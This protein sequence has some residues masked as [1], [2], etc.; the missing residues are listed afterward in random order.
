MKIAVIGAGNIGQTLGGKWAAAGHEVVYG[1]RSAG[2][3]GTAAIGDA[4]PGSEVVV[5]AVAGAAASCSAT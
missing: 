3:P 1:V 4:V 2:V 5:L